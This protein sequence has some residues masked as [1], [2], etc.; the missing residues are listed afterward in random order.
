MHAFFSLSLIGSLFLVKRKALI[1]YLCTN[2]LKLLSFS[3]GNKNH[4][5]GPNNMGVTSNRCNPVRFQSSY[6]QLMLRGS[7][8]LFA[9]APQEE[10]IS[11][12]NLKKEE[13]ARDSN[14]KFSTLD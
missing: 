11:A 5:L 13:R 14:L 2:Q 6:S 10:T 7:F 9:P 3:Y 1:F 8:Y 12:I 4:I